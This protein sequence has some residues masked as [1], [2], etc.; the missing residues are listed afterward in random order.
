MVHCC[1]IIITLL[2][3]YSD[4]FLKYSDL[5]LWNGTALFT[6]FAETGSSFQEKVMLVFHLR[7]FLLLMTVLRAFFSDSFQDLDTF[8]YLFWEMKY[9]GFI[10]GFSLKKEDGFW[11]VP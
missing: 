9:S 7:D 2:Y 5:F 8:Y 3:K 4:S 10:M 1:K 11:F 6:T